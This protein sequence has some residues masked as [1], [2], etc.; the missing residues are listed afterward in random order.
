MRE[1]EPFK[2]GVFGS[3]SGN[4]DSLF[5]KAAILGQ[6]LAEKKAITVVGTCM[7]LPYQ[8]ALAAKQAGGEV[9]LYP[10]FTSRASQERVLPQGAD[11]SIFK[12]I[13][14]IP[15]DDELADN[16]AACREYRITTS[17]AVCNGGVIFSGG[18]GTAAE[19]A[20][21]IQKGRVV[22]VLT[23]TSGLADS[24]K[25]LEARIGLK[26]GARLV[27]NPEPVSLVDQ[28][29]ERLDKTNV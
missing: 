10:P 5:A 25:D 17:T 21:L 8:T 9:W 28:L 22:G 11:L 24:L 18:W 26:P 12:K 14:T 27:Y 23:G 19:C 13:I 16:E 1:P 20:A 4:L 3:A 6:A 29:W 7:G 15:P 2:I